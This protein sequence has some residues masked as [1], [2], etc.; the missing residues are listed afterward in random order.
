MLIKK[1]PRIKNNIAHECIYAANQHML[2]FCAQKYGTGWIDGLVGGWVDGWMGGWV[3]GWVD[4][5]MGGRAGLRIAYSN[6]K[7]CEF[8]ILQQ[9]P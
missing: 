7:M 9:L 4:E 3:G 2:I 1:H 8:Q 6:Q 5:W